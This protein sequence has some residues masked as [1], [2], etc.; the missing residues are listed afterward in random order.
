MSIDCE[1]NERIFLAI[2]GLRS[3]SD[4]HQWFITPEGTWVYNKGYDS[5]LEV[6]DKWRKASVEEIINHFKD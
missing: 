5:I 4:I 6:S 3:D 1:V 2:A